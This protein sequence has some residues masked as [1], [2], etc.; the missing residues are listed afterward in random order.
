ME[1]SVTSP[2]N[3][4]DFGYFFALF[5]F[6]AASDGMF[7]A[8]A[9]M[10]AKNFFFGAAKRRPHRSYLGDN[11]DTITIFINHAGQ[12]PDLTLNSVEP[13]QHGGFGFSLHA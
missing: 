13:F 1:S 5:I 6:V 7:N 2:Q 8:V 10:I 3:I 4:D 9:H 11:V 12:A